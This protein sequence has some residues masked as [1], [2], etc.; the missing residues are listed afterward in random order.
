MAAHIVWSTFLQGFVQ[1][2]STTDS[3]IVDFMCK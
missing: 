1:E 2:L 3:C